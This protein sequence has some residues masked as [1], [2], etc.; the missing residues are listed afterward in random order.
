MKIHRFSYNFNF[1]QGLLMI[2]DREI[3][4][5]M[6]NVLKLKKSERIILVELGKKE[7][8]CE[9][10][11][12]ATDFLQLKLLQKNDIISAKAKEINLCCSVLKKDNFE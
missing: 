12:I 1:D 10:V 5:Q 2:K 6:K 3:I 9:I 11:N 8:L 7:A 4:H